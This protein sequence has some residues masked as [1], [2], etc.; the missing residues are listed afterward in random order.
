ME[1]RRQSN[2]ISRNIVSPSPDNNRRRNSDRVVLDVGGT[3]FVT[4]ISTL[5]ANSSYFKSMFSQE[6]HAGSNDEMLSDSDNDEPIFIDQEAASFAILLAYMRCGFIHMN[7]ICPKLLALAD[8]L[9]I[10]RL[11][12]AVKYRTYR[13]CFPHYFIDPVSDIIPAFDAEFGGIRGAI[14]KGILPAAL[15]SQPSCSDKKEFVSFVVSVDHA[16]HESIPGGLYCGVYAAN[17]LCVP[18]YDNSER[19]NRYAYIPNCRSFLDCIN[20]LSANG[21]VHEERALQGLCDTAVDNEMD[22]IMLSRLVDIS[23][24]KNDEYEDLYRNVI[25]G[26]DNREIQS[27]SC[28]RRYAMIKTSSDTFTYVLADLDHSERLVHDVSGE[29]LTTKVVNIQFDS[30]DE[31]MTWLHHHSYC[32]RET[33]YEEIYK[34]ALSKVKQTDRK[35]LMIFSKA[36]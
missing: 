5:R 32:T 7:E 30:P 1:A 36:L 35:L 6:W 25:I 20:W 27:V 16:Y 26:C 13:Y 17:K 12:D 24:S 29:N 11:L 22:V 10:D 19:G 18:S 23:G 8:F 4:S 28:K 9:G 21:F 14:S 3:Q 31:A 2:T 34:N 33:R 15:V